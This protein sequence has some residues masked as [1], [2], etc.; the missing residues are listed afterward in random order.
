MIY[1]LYFVSNSFIPK[2]RKNSVK[3]K[4]GIDILPV[5]KILHVIVS[6]IVEIKPIILRNLVKCLM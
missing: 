4:N 2:K 6:L 1:L 5:V 3:E